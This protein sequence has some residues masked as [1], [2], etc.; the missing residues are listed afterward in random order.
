[1]SLF[2]L[3]LLLEV[4]A[5]ISRLRAGPQEPPKKAR[6][7]EVIALSSALLCLLVHAEISASNSS[8]C[9]TRAARSA[10]RGS[11]GRSGCYI[12]V[13]SATKCGSLTQNSAIHP[14]AAG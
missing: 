5:C 13:A 11:F 3:Q 12:A 6:N 4:K 1:M 2:G 9:A 14:S 10:K 8:M 7:R